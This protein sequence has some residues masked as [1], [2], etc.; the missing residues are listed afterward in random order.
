M[1]RYTIGLCLSGKSLSA[2]STSTRAVLSP[3]NR[4]KPCKFRYAKSVRNFMWKL[5]YRKNDRAMRPIRGVPW[6]FSGLP[7]YAHGYYSQ[8]CS[9]A[10]VPID[11]TNVP[12]KFE[13]RSFTCSWG[14]R[15]TPKNWTVLGCA[16]AP[17]S[18]KILTGFYSEWPCKY[19]PKLE[20]RSFTCSW[21][22]RG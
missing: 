22:K 18:Q 9:W 5:Y 12:T 15:G 1:T 6:K 3:G 2:T 11:P 8:N 20:V 13:V 14:N 21:D 16:H 10:F 19:I 4:V 7:D 17:F